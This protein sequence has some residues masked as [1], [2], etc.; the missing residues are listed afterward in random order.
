M[1]DKYIWKAP[2]KTFQQL[3]EESTTRKIVIAKTP[4]KKSQ[5]TNYFDQIRETKEW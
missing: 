1:N 5:I 2:V 3:R 4:L